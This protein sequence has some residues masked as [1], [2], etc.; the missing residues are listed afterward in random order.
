[1]MSWRHIVDT[2]IPLHFNKIMLVNVLLVFIVS[3]SAPAPRGRQMGA[4][5]LLKL[6]SVT[7]VM[8]V[9]ALLV[10]MDSAYPQG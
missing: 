6:T 1:M 3:D 10:F 9:N 4:R 2:F 7:R 5:L 8:L